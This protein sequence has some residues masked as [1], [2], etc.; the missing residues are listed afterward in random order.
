MAW[1][2]AGRDDVG[3]ANAACLMR[4]VPMQDVPLQDVPLRACRVCAM[5]HL[6]G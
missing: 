1:A 5:P 2:V 4:D 6:V 3:S